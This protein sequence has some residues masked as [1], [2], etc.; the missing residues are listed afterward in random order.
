MAFDPSFAK[1]TE[2]RHAPTKS[3]SPLNVQLK[4][5]LDYTNSNSAMEDNSLAPLVCG[6]FIVGNMRSSSRISVKRKEFVE[7]ELAVQMQILQSCQHEVE[8]AE[9]N[10]RKRLNVRC[11]VA[12]LPASTKMKCVGTGGGRA[13]RDFDLR[14][15]GRLPPLPLLRMHEDFTI[16]DARCNRPQ[17]VG[18]VLPILGCE[19]H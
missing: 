7:L 6:R 14:D 16:Q 1:G 4:Q 5:E 3:S 19:Q 12:I 11:Q 13:D 2:R 15:E 8:K 10:H 18:F 9:D 17:T